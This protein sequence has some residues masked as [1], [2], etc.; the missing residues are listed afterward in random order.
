MP[1][2]CC[3]STVIGILTP[4][5]NIATFTS[6]W[7]G[8]C[9]AELNTFFYKAEPWISPGKAG[10]NIVC[11]ELAMIPIV[12]EFHVSDPNVSIPSL[13]PPWISE[14][15]LSWAH[16]L[17]HRRNSSHS[18]IT[19][20]SQKG[21]QTASGLWLTGRWDCQ[22]NEASFQVPNWPQKHPI[23]SGKTRSTLQAKSEDWHTHHPLARDWACT[24]TKHV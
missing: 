5:P 18:T 6:S 16:I 13:T 20:S 10:F 2:G 21:W 19:L 11:S 7:T 15:H 1:P 3:P 12:T 4:W 23:L 8:L 17:I 9:L 14:H 24:I 22:R